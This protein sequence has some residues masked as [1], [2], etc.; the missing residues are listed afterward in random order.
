MDITAAQGVST[1]N[2]A[3]AEAYGSGDIPALMEVFYAPGARVDGGAM[4]PSTTDADTII[5]FFQAMRD[6][7]FHTAELATATLAD[8]GDMAVETGLATLAGE[9]GQRAAI[10]YLVVWST[11]S[12]AWRVHTDF[13]A[14]AEG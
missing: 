4:L 2:A 8:E 14:P 3:F 6:Q 7:G 13:F 1:A 11:S 12:G 5:G 10:R 9:G